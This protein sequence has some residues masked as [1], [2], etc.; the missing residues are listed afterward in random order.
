MAEVTQNKSNQ[1]LSDYLSS[2]KILIVDPNGPAR[3]G[4][5]RMLVG[6]GAKSSNLTLVADYEVA[7]EV[8]QNLKPEV[9]IT[10]YTITKGTGLE[11]ASEFNKIK[12]SE[13]TLFVILT[14]NSSQ[15]IVAQAAEEDVDIYILKPYTMNYFLETLTKAILNK[16]SPSDYVK[17]INKGKQSLS[18]NKLDEALDYFE[19]AI[20]FSSTPSLAYYY[21]SQV[22][23]Q[24]KMYEIAEKS[25]EEG[26][27]FNEVHYKCLTGLFDLLMD[28]GKLQEAYGIVKRLVTFPLNPKRLSK[29]IELAVKTAHYSDIDKYYEAFKEIEFRDEEVIKHIC[30]AL[31]VSGKMLFQKGEMYKAASFL[32]KASV[33]AAGRSSILLEIVTT[34]ANNQF[35]PD[36]KEA[37]NRFT[38]E[39]QQ[40]FHYQVASFLIAYYEGS[41]SWK[42]VTW[43]RQSIEQGNSDVQLYYWTIAAL[44][45]SNKPDLAEDY[46]L[47]G[48][49]KWPEKKEFFNK[50]L[51]A[52]PAKKAL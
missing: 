7:R 8:I 17:K 40:E 27:K 46:L 11:L 42:H 26:L 24:K 38:P 4:M 31:V 22:E 52:I 23:I 39:S 2:K 5:A 15:S 36:A 49:K 33:S 44:Q 28:R 3:A 1:I 32:K 35:L 16:A 9:I 6:L 20:T 51:K 48:I 37:L 43:L 18:K 21:R 30:A 29:V 25:L 12:S 34:L 10:E 47:R 45:A 41:N 50:A 13:N 14:A 19:K